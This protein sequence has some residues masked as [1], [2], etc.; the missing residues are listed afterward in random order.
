M[1]NPDTFF[2]TYDYNQIVEQI[3]K[4]NNVP[5]D[6]NHYGRHMQEIKKKIEDIKRAYK[7]KDYFKEM[8]ML[9]KDYSS[10]MISN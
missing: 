7:S 10:Y 4:E 2:E 3:F 1:M 8:P 6:D 5:S 9:N